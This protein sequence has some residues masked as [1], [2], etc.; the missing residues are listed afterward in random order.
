MIRVSLIAKEVPSKNRKTSD[1]CFPFCNNARLLLT[2]LLL[3]MSRR[4]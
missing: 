3:I 2:G 4:T 1:C